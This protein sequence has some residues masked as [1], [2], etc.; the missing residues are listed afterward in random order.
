MMPHLEQYTG[1][2]YS[3][4]SSEKILAVYILNTLH[5]GVFPN[6]IFGSRIP[7][8]ENAYFESSKAHDNESYD[9]IYHFREVGKNERI[10]TWKNVFPGTMILRPLHGA[11]FSASLFP[12]NYEHGIMFTGVDPKGIP[13][14]LSNPYGSSPL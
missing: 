8:V 4:G 7:I 1:E 13:M 14:A 11:A 2:Y 10:I 3:P 5:P 12:G 6:N 9:L